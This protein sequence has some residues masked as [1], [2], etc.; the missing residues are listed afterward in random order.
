[1]DG[2]KLKLPAREVQPLGRDHGPGRPEAG[3]APGWG[4]ELSDN[5]GLPDRLNILGFRVDEAKAEVER[6]ID[7]ASLSGLLSVAILHGTGTGALK[8]AVAE[9][10][11]SHPLV[12]ATRPGKQ[13]EGGAGV[14]VAELKK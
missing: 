12:A 7:R 10:L 14:T 1:M 2:K 11:E 8:S 4:A 9:C 3:A 6:F 13:A 5:E